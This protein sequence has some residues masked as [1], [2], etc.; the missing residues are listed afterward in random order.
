MA[1][2]EMNQMA[3]T[4]PVAETVSSQR[5]PERNMARVRVFPTSQSNQWLVVGPKKDMTVHAV[6]FREL[7]DGVR[8]ARRASR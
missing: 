7:L 4:S 8:S 1:P 6:T 3:L 2:G 5:S